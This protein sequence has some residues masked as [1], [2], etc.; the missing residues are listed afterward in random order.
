MTSYSLLSH[1]PDSEKL[2]SLVVDSNSVSKE[3]IKDFY[4]RQNE[5]IESMKE[6]LM[7]TE[8]EDNEDEEKPSTA[9]YV[10]IQA[11]L[12]MTFVLLALKLTAAITSGSVAILASSIDSILDVL[13]QGTLLFTSRLM[14]NYD[15]YR[16]PGGKARLEPLS[17]TMFSLIMGVASLELLY[18]SIQVLIEH[19]DGTAGQPDISVLTIVILVVVV[20]IQTGMWFYC[21]AVASRDIPGRDAADALAQDHLND[22]CINLMGGIPAIISGFV[23]A[24]GFLDPIGG[25]CLSIYIF[26]R[27][28]KTC[29]EQM[30]AM[31]GKSASPAFLSQLTF[32][33]ATH[34]PDIKVVDTVLAYHVSNQ[35]QV[36]CHV[37]VDGDLPLRVAH[38][39]GESLEAKFER[40][41]DVQMAFVHLDF[42]TAHK[43]EHALRLKAARASAREVA[44]RA[45]T[46]E[47]TS[48]AEEDF[49]HHSED[50]FDGPLTPTS[51]QSAVQLFSLPK[52]QRHS[53]TFEGNEDT[54]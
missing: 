18:Q 34:S 25:I 3:S 27:W 51:H 43:P 1:P 5:L 47:F 9:A 22:V 7:Q 4:R 35:Y 40:L 16:Y 53:D 12:A 11:S 52:N 48:H 10:A 2:S 19:I 32:L 54:V 31:S 26:I 50:K 13:S 30:P 6:A 45:L 8:K 28:M 33:A 24:V 17:V 36:E 37:M 21:R 20:G 44:E 29:W 46:R 38:D 15:P 39:I 49:H 14:Q 42:D 23:E 41:K